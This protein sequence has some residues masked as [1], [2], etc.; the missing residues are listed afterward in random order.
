M[1]SD[2]KVALDHGSSKV[3]AETAIGLVAASNPAVGMLY[4]AYKVAQFSYPIV[5]AGVEEYSKTDDKDKAVEKMAAET[6]KQTGN[7]VVETAA[8]AVAGALV[9]GAAKAA[10]E[11]IVG[12]VKEV[13]KAAVSEAISEEIERHE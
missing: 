4:A 1:S 7:A 13:V 10:N 2:L 11:R 12:P 3:V 9:N 8:D 6:S 5:K